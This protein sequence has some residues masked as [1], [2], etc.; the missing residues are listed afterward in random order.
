ME[1]QTAIDRAEQLAERISDGDEQTPALVTDPAGL[2]DALMK[3]QAD[4]CRDLLKL[5]A[6][7]RKPCNGCRKQIWFVKSRNG[8]MVPFSDQGTLHSVECPNADQFSRDRH[9]SEVH[10]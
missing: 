10:A 9:T 2:V 7:V 6:V 1:H 8:A 5:V 4:A 3:L